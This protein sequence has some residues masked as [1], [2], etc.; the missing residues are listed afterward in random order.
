MQ[1]AATEIAAEA[2]ASIA[3]RAAQAVQTAIASNPV[4]A[5]VVATAIGITAGGALVYFGGRY[6]ADAASAGYESACTWFRSSDQVIN[7]KPHPAPLPDGGPEAP[8]PGE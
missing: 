3:G 4:V 2:T 6:V 1:N 7:V 5:G 8:R